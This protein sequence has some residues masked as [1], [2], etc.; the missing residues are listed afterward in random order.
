MASLA[1]GVTTAR[2]ITVTLSVDPRSDLT[3][4]SR[5]PVLDGSVTI[6]ANSGYGMFTINAAANANVESARIIIDG[7]SLSFTVNQGLVTV[8]NKK[9]IPGMAVSNN[10]DGINEY[11]VISNIEKYP[12]NVVSIHDR[13][14]LLVYQGAGYNNSGIVF[15]GTSNQ[16]RAYTLPVGT[17]YYVV[18]FIDKTKD[19]NNTNQEYYYG[20]FQLKH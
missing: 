16:G 15:N 18:K 6:P 12:N 11:L 17:Y 19:P 10:G 20:Y 7:S 8:S 4:L 5:Q 9:I 14:G 2:P 1:S 3:S 13:D